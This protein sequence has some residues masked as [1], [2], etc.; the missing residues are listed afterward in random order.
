[1][2]FLPRFDRIWLPDLG[3][4]CHHVYNMM[5]AFGKYFFAIAK[6]AIRPT[7]YRSAEF[8]LCSGLISDI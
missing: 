1:M 7:G 2:T 4:A 3:Q 6:Q 8:A 5:T